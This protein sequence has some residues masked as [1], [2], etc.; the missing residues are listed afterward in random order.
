MDKKIVLY[1]SDESAT[2]VEN[3]KGWVSKSGR[4]Y[5]EDEHMARWD[6]C[7][8]KKCECGGITERS[9]TICDK[10]RDKK[11]LNKYYSFEEI[12]WDG[13]SVVCDYF[14]GK[15]YFNGIDGIMEDCENEDYSLSSV[16]LCN[17]KPLRVYPIYAND[18]FENIMY[19]DMDY[20]PKEIEDAF[21][22]LNKKLIVYKE[23]ISYSC[24][25][26][27]IDLIKT[28]KKMRIET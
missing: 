15:F 3:M 21:D 27:R 12:D 2:Y 7:T 4:F 22:E 16:K 14:N 23:P 1:A 28:I 25:N 11:D 10:C 9:Y 20:F 8:H 26:K 5:G 19:D 17:A 18:V 24:G 13:E 6:G